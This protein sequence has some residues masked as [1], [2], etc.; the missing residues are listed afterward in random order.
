MVKLDLLFQ[1]V[2]LTKC[3]PTYIL[4][5]KPNKLYLVVYQSG[6]YSKRFY[7]FAFVKSSVNSYC[8][9]IDVGSNKKLIFIDNATKFYQFEEI[10]LCLF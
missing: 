8:E 6:Y 7:K 5:V 10:L 4:D 1:C 2:V 3:K 9:C